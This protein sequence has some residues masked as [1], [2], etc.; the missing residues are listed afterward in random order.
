MPKLQ[1]MPAGHC[2]STVQSCSWVQP[3][4]GSPVKPGKQKHGATWL[5]A[6]QSVFWPQT[7]GRLHTSTHLLWTH[8][9]SPGQSLLARHSSLTQRTW[10]LP[11]VRGG[12]EHMGRWLA[13]VQMASAPQ[14]PGTSQ[15]F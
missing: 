2:S 5:V 11:L 14:D 4:V 13:G 15:G 9:L 8:V 6:L 12:Q 3:N 10:G 7:L 1:S